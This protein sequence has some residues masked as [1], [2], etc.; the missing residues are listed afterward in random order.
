MVLKYRGHS[1]I[2]YLHRKQSVL[3]MDDYIVQDILPVILIALGAIIILMQGK[4][5]MF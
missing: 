3:V 4:Q 5:I 2:M 1:V